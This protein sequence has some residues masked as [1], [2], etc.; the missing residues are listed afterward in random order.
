MRVTRNLFLLAIFLLL[1][2]AS[3]ANYQQP[4]ADT[5]DA[6][7]IPRFELTGKLAKGFSVTDCE[8]I[9][10]LTCRVRFNGA[11]PLPSEIFFTE[12]DDQ[13]K[14][15]GARVRLI[16]PELKPGETGRATFRIRTGRPAKIVLRGEWNGAYR[17]PY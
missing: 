6:F 10:G 12:F 15:A 9:S 16:Y 4:K 13:G 14:Q 17:N 7:R 1:D 11:I 5:E 3:W 2:A 8:Y